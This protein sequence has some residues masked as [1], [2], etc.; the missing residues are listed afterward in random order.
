MSANDAVPEAGKLR[1]LLV[2]DHPVSRRGVAATLSQQ[3]DLT[4]GAEADSASQALEAL[5]HTPCDLAIVDLILKDSSGLALI[6][7]IRAR[8]PHLPVVALSM[9][10]EEVYAQRAFQAGACAYV[11]KVETPDRLL[12][13][14]RTALAGGIYLSERAMPKVLA[15][16]VDG[17]AGSA[18]DPL[19]NREVEIL[20]LI[21]QGLP[22][23]QIAE[24]LRISP[25]TVEA[26]REHIKTKLNLGSAPALMKYAMDW[27][28]PRQNP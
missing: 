17:G 12:S 18:M 16:V 7:D 27:V 10:D 22:T 19:T 20:E 5:E 3:P 11:S 28:R 15:A 24:S 14:I 26:H 4:V 25:H 6:Q 8:Y 9:Q 21:G 2:D 1:I 13:A 23:R